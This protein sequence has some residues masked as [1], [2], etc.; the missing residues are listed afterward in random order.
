MPSGFYFL[1]LSVTLRLVNEPAC[2]GQDLTFSC[3]APAE[4][5]RLLTWTLTALPDVSASPNAFGAILNITY[6]RITSPDTSQG[7]NPSSITIL[8]ATTV[9]NGAT[10]QCRI[11][12][13]DSS[14]V[15]N[16]SI[17]E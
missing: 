4:E 2:S 14:N 16:L 10:V 1:P 17:R 6:E 13:G 7:P 15:I 8:N 5:A 3:E 11:V 9:D 12:N